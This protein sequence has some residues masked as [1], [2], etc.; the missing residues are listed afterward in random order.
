VIG[1]LDK[2]QEF[3]VLTT[4]EILPRQHLNKRII[5]AIEKSKAEQKSRL[6]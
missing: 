5:G 2:A 1:Q 6:T 3:R 4:E